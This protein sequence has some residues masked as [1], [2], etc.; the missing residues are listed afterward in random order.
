MRVLMLGNSFTYCHDM[1]KILAALLGEE[2]VSITRG[3]AYLREQL[4]TGSE[5]GLKTQ[6]ALTEE[7]WDYVVMQE[8]SYGPVAHKDSFQES[9][10]ELCK[11]IRAAGAKPVLYASWAYKEDSAKLASVNA[12]YE[13]MAAGLYASYHEAAEA[14]DALVADVGKAFDVV[15][16]IIDLYE[17]DCYHPSPAGSVLAA[18]TIAKVI[19]NDRR[20][21]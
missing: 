18:H 17:D 11:K 4:D 1:P 7:K 2:V 10:R 13:E 5:M 21:G 19:E 14:N 3:G 9:V 6:K 20:N 12:T 8:Q 16:G 15:R